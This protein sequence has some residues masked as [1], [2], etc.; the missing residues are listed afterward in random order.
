[1][2]TTVLA[3]AFLLLALGG[4]AGRAAGQE[5]EPPPAPERTLERSPAPEPEPE[6]HRILPETGFYWQQGL[7]FHIKQWLGVTDF[8]LSGRIGAKVAVDGGAFVSQ[9]AVQ[10]VDN[11]VE[12]R[13]ARV[14]VLGDFKLGWPGFYKFEIGLEGFQ[15]V[16]V[17]NF[18]GL[19]D[20]PYIGSIAA[21]NLQTPIG[22]E[23]VISGRD[24]TF[25]ELSSPL[26]AFAPGT[27]PGVLISNT[28]FNERM[29]WSTGIF[30]SAGNEVLG[31]DSGLAQLMG[32]ITGLPIDAGA[33]GVVGLL[34]LGLSASGLLSGNQTVRYRSRPESFLAPVQVDTHEIRAQGAVLLGLEAAVV[35]GPLS[36]QAEYIGT[37]VARDKGPS[38]RFG[39]GYVSASYFLTGESRPYDRS[40][41]LFGRLKPLRP[42]SFRG[43]G[44]GAWELVAR[45]SSLDL[46]DGSI[47]GG[48]QKIITLG[49]NWYWNPYVKMRFNYGRAAI[50][51]P[52]N[53]GDGRL[54][55]FQGR[56]ELDF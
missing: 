1:V 49:T 2:R 26:A 11:S 29:T 36:V 5:R 14:Y 45:Y 50:D 10:P 15:A 40:A 43:D 47:R 16:L 4:A 22:L 13:R 20:L 38:V 33:E 51:L 54:H 18:L 30:A 27:K 48:T 9:G 39:G 17:E 46:D 7:N 53:E 23:A 41:G 32:R 21:G 44:W 34:H 3:A 42:L 6:H 56:F 28:A 37:Q 12:L 35:R 25:L 52:R 24:L 8:S 19:K 55:I 31:N